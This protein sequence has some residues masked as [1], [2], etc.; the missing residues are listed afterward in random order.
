MSLRRIATSTITP[1]T[2]ARPW[3]PS[4]GPDDYPSSHPRGRSACS[5]ARSRL[6][7]LRVPA[8]H[9][10]TRCIRNAGAHRC[11]HPLPIT[12]PNPP[13]EASSQP[14]ARPEGSSVSGG[15]LGLH[16][17]TFLAEGGNRRGWQP[18]HSTPRHR[19]M[20]HHFPRLAYPV[21]GASLS[22]T[23]CCR[24]SHPTLRFSPQTPRQLLLSLCFRDRSG[25]PPTPNM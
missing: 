10:P 6:S 15:R 17:R 22:A 3:L 8:S 18:L 1:Q 25:E 21:K 19:A 23:S 20:L 7:P 16:E 14:L 11:G 4:L 5:G 12:V 13:S 9:P 2:A 24:V